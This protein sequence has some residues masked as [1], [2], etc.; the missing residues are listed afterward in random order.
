GVRPLESGAVEV[1]GHDRIVGLERRL[2]ARVL[3]NATGPWADRTPAALLGSL[4]PGAAHP[5]PLLR[6]SRGIH[7]G[8]P[9][10]TPG[11]GVL[12]VARQDG[13]VLFVIPFAGHALVGTTEVEITSPIETDALAPSVEEV[14]YL[15]AELARAF[16]RTGEM[17][18][19]AVTSGVRPL[20]ATPGAV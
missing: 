20:I 10:F 5:P 11:H 12:W 1:L 6:P 19:L 4:R 16:P 15:R 9:A 8:F 3:I 7:L 14:R 13:R 17:P 18:A 2:G